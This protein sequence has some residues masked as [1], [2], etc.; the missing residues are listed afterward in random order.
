MLFGSSSIFYAATQRNETGAARN[1]GGPSDTSKGS[2]MGGFLLKLGLYQCRPTYITPTN[3]CW[4]AAGASLTLKQ[5]YE[6]CSD[7]VPN[8]SSNTLGEKLPI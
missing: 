7:A 5:T 2:P 4:D 3:P 8:Y 6:A 1:K